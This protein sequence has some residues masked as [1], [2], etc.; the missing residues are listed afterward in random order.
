MKLF[1]TV[2][3]VFILFGCSSSDEK[4]LPAHILD[5]DE[6]AMVMIDVQLAEGM[7]AQR[8]SISQDDEGSVFELYKAIFEKHN[9]EEDEFM[10]TYDYY[11][12]H[13]EQME[14]VYEQVLDSL[15][16]LDAEVKQEYSAEQKAR[17]DSLQEVRQIKLDSLRKI[18][19]SRQ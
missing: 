2:V 16:K 3:L 15:N 8:I 5:T 14:K 10:E 9:V 1:R 17:S 6:F 18:R 11:R 4:K 19:L 13:P 7:K 12:K